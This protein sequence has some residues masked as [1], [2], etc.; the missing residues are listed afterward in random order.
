MWR[1]TRRNQI[2]SF[3]ETDESIEI[4]G[5]GRGASVQ[6][7]TGSRG[8]RISGSNAVY[9]MFRGSVKS[10]GYPLH[11]PASPFTSPP[12]RRRVPSHFNWSLLQ[13]KGIRLLLANRPGV[14][15]V[16][17]DIAAKRRI[18]T[19]SS[20]VENCRRHYL[21]CRRWRRRAVR[22]ACCR[23][24]SV[25]SPSCRTRQETGTMLTAAFESLKNLN[26]VYK[27]LQTLF[28]ISVEVICR[29]LH[30]TFVPPRTKTSFRYISRFA[31]FLPTNSVYRLL[32][33]IILRWDILLR[34]T[35]RWTDRPTGRSLPGVQSTR[36]WTWMGKKL[37][38]YYH[39]SLT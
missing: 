38:L 35:G 17:E 31:W 37:P 14:P 34:W 12:V 13:V 19:G 3:G 22:Y 23:R 29:S 5:G 33:R 25:T 4:C 7:N 21:H 32:T 16:Y 15:W 36:P 27:E 39:Q 20:C 1:H 2:S 11:S 10:T 28:P 6:S 26:L 8:V 24:K 30:I 18:I 9:T